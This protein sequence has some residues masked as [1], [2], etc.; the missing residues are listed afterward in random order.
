MPASVIAIVV[1]TICYA[2]FAALSRVVSAELAVFQQLTIRVGIGA[3]LATCWVK[4][5]RSL[6]SLRAI[7]IKDWKLL[8]IRSFF[9]YIIGGGCFVTAVTTTSIAN[10]AFL[11]AF[12]FEVIIAP[13]LL[14][15]SLSKQVV[16]GFLICVIGAFLVSI[17]GITLTFGEGE[18]LS[19][20]SALGIAI[21]Y[22]LRRRH[23]PNFSD[24]HMTPIILWLGAIF[25]GIAALSTEGIPGNVSNY[26]WAI[27]IGLGILNAVVVFLSNYAFR[28]IKA[29]VAGNLLMLEIPFTILFGYLFFREIPSMMATIGGTLVVIGAVISH[30]KRTAGPQPA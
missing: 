25:L 4:E 15:E 8:I 23:S 18:L 13:I 3:L 2:T 10:V 27:S 14:K 5:S 16:V 26:M 11:C 12:P 24:A 17:N 28:K 9:G 7:S 30:E 1:L 19:L 21:Y 6:S 22:V 20:C 29:S